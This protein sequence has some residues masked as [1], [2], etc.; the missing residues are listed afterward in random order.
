LVDK[1]ECYWE[2]TGID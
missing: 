2:Y 1:I